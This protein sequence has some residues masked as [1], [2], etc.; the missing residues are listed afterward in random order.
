MVSPQCACPRIVYGDVR[1]LDIPYE[2]DAGRCD[3]SA[4]ARDELGRHDARSIVWSDAIP[5]NARLVLVYVSDGLRN[6]H[7]CLL[8]LWYV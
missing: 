4:T 7:G 2:R 1:L 3:D 8:R 6:I 5:T